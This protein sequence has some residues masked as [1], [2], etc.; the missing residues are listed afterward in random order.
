[1]EEILDDLNKPDSLMSDPTYT[2]YHTYITSSRNLLNKI[3]FKPNYGWKF[4]P[5]PRHLALRQFF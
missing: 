3:M 5:N 1:M 4:R 2:M